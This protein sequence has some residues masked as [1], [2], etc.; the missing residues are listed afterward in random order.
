M[1]SLISASRFR[2]QS[3]PP[4]FTIHAIVGNMFVPA[5]TGKSVADGFY[6]L[7]KPLKPGSHRLL[8]S[9]TVPL[10]DGSTFVI[11]TNYSVK[12]GR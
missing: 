11:N 12:V 10:S 4:P 3:P 7:I 1:T 6:V 5:G 9:G 8:F 2:V